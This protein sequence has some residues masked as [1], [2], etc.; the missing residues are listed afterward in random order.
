MAFKKVTY[1]TGEDARINLVE[2]IRSKEDI[3]RIINFFDSKNWHKYAVIFKLGV[4]SGLRISDILGLHVKD[5]KGRNDIVLREQKTGK[6]KKFPLKPELQ[7]MLND[8]I[9]DKLD[10]DWMFEGRKNKKLDRSQVYRRINDAIEALKID[11]NVGTHTLRKTFGYHH[12]RQFH[13]ITLLQTIF[14]HTSPEV[15]KRYIGITQDEI[16]NTYLGLNLDK[17]ADAFDNCKTGATSRIRIRRVI[18]FCKAYIKNGGQTHKDFALTILEIAN[19]API[20]THD[21]EEMD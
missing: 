18:A 20:D 10:E 1:K 6:S 4:N 11:A 5:V 19:N 17:N 13:D 3:E 2:P 8:W 21:K 12:Y 7:E 14:N 15:T 9:G 16:D